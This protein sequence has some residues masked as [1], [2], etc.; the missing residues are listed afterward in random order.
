MRP[1]PWIGACLVLLLVAG[2]ISGSA[3]ADSA[4]V[5]T[6]V[7]PPAGSTISTTTPNITA[8]FADNSSRIDPSS[9]DI[10]VDGVDVTTLDS[11][12]VNASGV[13]YAV[14]QLLRLGN[15]NHTVTI[16]ASDQAGNHA[17]YSWGFIVNTTQQSVAP[18]ISIQ[19]LSLLFDIGLGSAVVAAAFGLYIFYLK[20][21]KR[22]TFRKYFAT[23]PVK[24]QYVVLYIPAIA[25][26]FFLLFGLVIVYST[27]GLPGLAPDYVIV[28]AVFIA[29]TAYA[30][31]A[32]REKRKIRVYER[33]FAQLL[34]EMADAMR[35][36]IDPAKAIVELSKTHTN[37]LKKHLR[38]AAD[39][40]RLGRR[41]EDV[42]QTMVGSMK[43]P[44]ISRYAGL[45][46]DASTAGGETSAVV[47]RAAKDMDD[48][49][50]IGVER[51]KELVMPV[52]VI[53]I[54]F[55]VLLA[56]LFSLLN[57]APTLGSINIGLFGSTTLT[58]GAPA[59][60]PRLD[61][62]TLKQRFFHLM[63]INSVG[64]GA[65][66]GT[67]T[68]GKAKYGLI[69]SLIMAAVTVVAFALFFP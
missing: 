45:I 39:G 15:G 27:P 4:I 68:E 38:I 61:F 5:I 44:L 66:I 67:F 21:K 29:L 3:R 13:N 40:I 65:L 24:K 47:Y 32:R 25:A 31:D 35:G 8:T 60:L 63:L 69:H 46:A 9:V 18:I 6:P 33:A 1:V 57:I 49:I 26:F 59:V 22:F 58:P 28:G 52:A 62:F 7:S 50:K 54:A 11:T 56:V 41:F 19:P 37:I 17:E 42:L 43:S 48:F 20:Q 53:Y 64:T 14:P 2:G 36:G 51:G 10:A 30:V 12:K 16:S 23:H 55:G 34:F